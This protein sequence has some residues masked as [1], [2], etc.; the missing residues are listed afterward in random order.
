MNGTGLNRGGKELDLTGTA[1][2]G[3]SKIKILTGTGM[4][5]RGF[6]R[7]GDEQSWSGRDLTGTVF[8]KFVP[9][10]GVYSTCALQSA[11]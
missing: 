9:P 4:N 6:N 10:V 11:A 2:N 7:A 8:P 1:M 5:G 3:L